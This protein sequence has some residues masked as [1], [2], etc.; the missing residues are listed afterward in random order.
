MLKNSFKKFLDAGPEADDFQNG[1]ILNA[2]NITNCF[3]ELFV[4]ES[5][6]LVNDNNNANFHYNPAEADSTEQKTLCTY[7][8]T[9]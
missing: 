5:V 4:Y 7:V 8:Q 2:L 3:D 9:Q 1:R 6:F